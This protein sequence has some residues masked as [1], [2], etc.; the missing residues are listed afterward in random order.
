MQRPTAICFLTAL[1]ALGLASSAALADTPPK[2]TLT[3]F[4]DPVYQS[5]G[6]GEEHPMSDLLA[7]AEKGDTRAQFI[8]GDLYAKGKGGLVKNE[9]KA[10]KLFEDSAKNGY[11][12]SYIRLGA[13]AKRRGD[14][15][16]AWSWYDLGSS[17]AS[18]RDAR[19]SGRAR[20]Q[21]E[22]IG[23]L[24]G[25]DISAARKLSAEYRRARD[26]AEQKRE[27][28]ARAARAEAEAKKRAEERK[29]ADTAAPA[30]NRKPHSDRTAGGRNDK[31]REY[32]PPTFTQRYND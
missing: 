5:V 22:E 25:D 23:K 15:I 7:L 24:S 32:T 21:V 10:A 19:Y 8:L 18:G 12:P 9:E 1:V 27:E 16:A 17:L 30:N 31:P 20:D 4:E 29:D 26:E 11:G 2:R 3:Y 14:F 13:L 6:E 28:A